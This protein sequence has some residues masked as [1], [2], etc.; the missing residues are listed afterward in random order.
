MF[1]TIAGHGAVSAS[2]PPGSTMHTAG[3]VTVMDG[4]ATTIPG[5]TDI[6]PG[7]GA[8]ATDLGAGVI[9]DTVM[10]DIMEAMEPGCPITDIITVTITDIT[11]IGIMP[12]IRHEGDT[13][14]TPMP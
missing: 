3:A 8:T 13:T 12:T 1:T 10:L 5:D 11:D 6:V 14:A 9:T 2:V 4:E 7:D